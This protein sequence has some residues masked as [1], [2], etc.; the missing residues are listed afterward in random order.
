M[1]NRRWIEPLLLALLTIVLIAPLF[2]VEYF[3]NWPS[4]ESTFIADARMLREH[5]PHPGWQPVWYMGT[6]FDYVYPPAL[7]YGTALIS[8]AAGTSTAR[9][10]HLYIGTFYVLGIL[11]VWLL[12]RAGSGSRWQAGLAGAA[13]ALVSP[14]AWLLRAV[15]TDNADWLPQRLYV[16]MQYGEGPHI[17]ALGILPTALAA[18]LLALQRK[19]R[20]W[21]AA[22]AILSALVVSN[23]F[24]GATA[25]G[26]FFPLLVWAVFV[27]ERDAGV[28]ARS[29]AIALLAYGLCAFWLTPSYFRITM[30]NLDT[31][32]EP[33]NL[34]SRLAGVAI[35]LLF[36]L[37][38]WRWCRG[39][40]ERM[41]PTFT[42][43]ATVVL[44][45]YV[46]GYYLAH[47]RIAGDAAR[48]AP[49]L[50]L[51]L[52]LAAITAAAWLWKG[53]PFLRI[54]A[55]AAMVVLFAPTTIY[56][57][58]RH[59]VFPVSPPLENQYVWQVA[60]WVES[61]LP[62]QRVLP[63]G[64][65]R[66]WMDA[67]ANNAQ[68]DG[69]SKQGLLNTQQPVAIWQLLGY[70]NS[71]LAR[72]WLQAMGTSAVIVAGPGSREF[73]L[74]FK[75]PEKFKTGFSRLWDDGHNTTIYGVPRV[76]NSLGRVVDATAIQAMLP[77]N[78]GAGEAALRRYLAEVERA[79]RP[80][81]GVA[82]KGFDEVTL[83]ADVGKG[84][85]VLL[86]ETFDPAWH[87][88]DGARELPIRAERPM[89]FMLIET[90]EGQHEI[91]MRFKTPAENRVGQALLVITALLCVW[92]IAARPPTGR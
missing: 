91:Q 7:R 8:L 73:Y 65:V 90:G 92:L 58:H 24:Y 52:T 61:N 62:G 2:R 17:T 1:K 37:A 49:E 11:A 39:R 40:R 15:R 75:F 33:G 72:L 45:Y 83:R 80:E 70:P 44:L 19:S 55:C 53:R 51:A 20:G 38:S 35:L 89:D 66:F 4:I 13:T 68:A 69:G 63:L 41:W 79:D 59:L 31:V 67:W 3:N 77:L 57:R 84:Q 36:G 50:D 64:M 22:A 71:D 6:R 14:C 30:A 85:A 46:A 18:S 16:L 88:Y 12:V 29:A 47:V 25:L 78:D 74:D 27:T 9:A 34:P 5:L 32:A 81:V 76:H 48:L 26:I 56:L 21:T 82:W 54:V 43:G 23:N 42:A 87:A 60:R 86:Q 10:Y 28:L